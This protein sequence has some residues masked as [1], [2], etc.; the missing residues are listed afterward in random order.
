MNQT[1]SGWFEDFIF[2]NLILP[3]DAKSQFIAKDP[4]SGEDWGQEEKRAPEVEMVEWHHQLNGHE[5]EQIPGD[6][7][8]QGILVCCSPWGH[9]ESDMAEWLSNNNTIGAAFR[10]IS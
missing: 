3:P 10:E 1:T 9:K 5:S 6:S 4:D 8:G 2:E 7:E